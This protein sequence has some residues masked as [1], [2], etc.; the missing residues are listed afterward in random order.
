M[1]RAA[2]SL[3]GRPIPAGNDPAVIALLPQADDL[4][5]IA[6]DANGSLLGAAWLRTHDPPLV[7]GGDGESLPEL[8]MAVVEQARG[9]GIGG[10]LIEALAEHATGRVPGLS[11]NVHLLN[12]AV[13]LYMRSGFTVAGAGRGRFGVAMQRSL[14]S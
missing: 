1:A 7:V 11:L 5:L 4:A 10:A 6:A 12:P 3:A 14:A 8:A 13:R 2:C 9:R